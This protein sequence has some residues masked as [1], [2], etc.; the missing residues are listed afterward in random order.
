MK[1]R[2]EH[3]FLF[4]GTG[5]KRWLSRSRGPKPNAIFL[6]KETLTP[7]PKTDF[8]RSTDPEMLR[9]TESLADRLTNEFP[10]DVLPSGFAGPTAV[11][12]TFYNVLSVSGHGMDPL[13]IPVS[14]NAGLVSSLGLRDTI[15]PGDE[16]WLDE[17]IDLFFG[18]VAPADTHIRK[19][20]STSFPWFTSDISYKKQALMKIV[21]NVDDFLNLATG[22]DL[23]L[24]ELLEKYH[25]LFVYAIHER[26]Q[27]SSVSKAKDGSYVAKT[28]SAP[29][30]KE[31]REGTYDG[32]T[33]ANME[34]YDSAGNVIPNHFA[35]RR[36]DVFGMNGPVNYFLTT[37][38]ASFREVY[39]NRF[40]FTYKTR[41]REDK[42]RKIAKYQYTIGSDV[43]TMDK[44]IPRWFVDY[45]FNKLTKYL[46]ERVV[47][48]MR[49]IYRAPYVVPP[50]W[51]KTAVDYDPVFGG[52]PL[53]GASFDNHV[54]LPS[55]IAFNPDWGKLWMTFVYVILY[56]DCQALLQP[57]DIEPFLRGNDK[58][59]ALLDMA[60]DGAFLTN[61]YTVALRLK[62]AKSPYALLEPETPVIF[63]GDVFVEEGG[64]KAVYANPLTYV[65]NS[66][67]REDSID[68]I[69]GS[70][71]KVI[72]YA[73]GQ[74]ARFQTYS[75]TPIFRD[76][77]QIVEEEMKRHL[78]FNPMTIN[79]LLARNQRYGEIDALVKSNPG[80]IHYKIDPKLVSPEVLDSIVA[81]V[82]ASDTW[83]H[84]QH[85]FKKGMNINVNP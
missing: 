17:I 51:K 21:H 44:T 63:L 72:S 85:L 33:I 52:N 16:R 53:E 70:P 31:A 22:D 61:S 15:R 49:R 45:V 65:V 38:F 28:R 54:G 10:I 20:G 4:E 46:D 25:T 74:L 76:M 73:E 12:G 43:K 2:K 58:E 18:H 56:R 39:L 75:G 5:A 64:K 19:E 79:R 84:V 24:K 23:S 66:L 9:L 47:E 1:I 29:T 82:P 57:S 71:N 6:R 67:C 55:G 48:L 42:R 8:V 11:A 80:V 62:E 34:V 40:E 69:S 37:I 7:D 27:P 68:K 30:E 59:H 36:R 41:D 32:K 35:M 78:G 81:T 77:N 26:Q 14:N 83:P 13:P 50:P 3:A 60:D